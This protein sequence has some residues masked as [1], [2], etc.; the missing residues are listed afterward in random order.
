MLAPASWR[1]DYLGC[2]WIH[3]YTFI[4]HFS[5]APEEA[6]EAVCAQGLPLEVPAT[7]KAPNSTLLDIHLDEDLAGAG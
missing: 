3:E 1:T 4:N 7:R 6:H 5:T 2:T